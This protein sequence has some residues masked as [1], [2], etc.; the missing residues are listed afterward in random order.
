MIKPNL[1]VVFNSKPKAS[2]NSD[3]KFTTY[4][5]Y[6]EI[7]DIYHTWRHYIDGRL[8][9]EFNDRNTANV[10]LNTKGKK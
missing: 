5:D 6:I 7:R 4:D 10:E 3:C 8:E 1:F 9:M 2:R